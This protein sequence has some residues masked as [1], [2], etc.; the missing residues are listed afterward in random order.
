LIDIDASYIL[1]LFI[2]FEV[3]PLGNLF[4]YTLT[5]LSN[6]FNYFYNADVMDTLSLILLSSLIYYS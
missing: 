5:S 2:G 6:L 3:E 4:I 1:Y